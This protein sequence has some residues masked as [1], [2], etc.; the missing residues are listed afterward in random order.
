MKLSFKEPVR[1]TDILSS[2]NLHCIKRSSGA[3]KSAPVLIAIS[4]RNQPELLARALASAFSQTLVEKKIAQI[5]ILDDQSDC[6]WLEALENILA[7]PS[8]TILKA[9]CGSPAR[10]RNT[11]LDWAD[12]QKDI[13]WV[14]RLDADDE[15]FCSNSLEALYDS[16][17]SG[18]NIAAIGSNALRRNNNVIFDENIASSKILLDPDRLTSFI[19][20]FC[21]GDQKQELPS[22]NL[23]L[24]THTHLRYPGIRS[25]EDHWLLLRIL[26]LH[27]DQVSVVEAPI[28]SIY[29]LGGHSTVANRDKGSW[30]SSR[31]KLAWVADKVR[32]TQIRRYH[33]LGFGME[34]VVFRDAKN[35][36]KEFYPWAM[37]DKEVS[38]LRLILSSKELPIP[39]GQWKKSENEWSYISK[40]VYEQRPEQFI[41]KDK[42]VSFLKVLY[43]NRVV[44]LNIKRANLMYSQA[45]ELHYIDVGK[46]I[47]NLTTSYFLD[48]TAR[49]YAIGILG[50]SDEEMMRR[51]SIKKPDDALNEIP[52][53]SKF[54]HD[55]IKLL[56]PISS[57]ILDTPKTTNSKLDV[58]LLIK[59]CAQDAEGL[60]RQVEHI[61]TQ[62]SYPEKFKRI[63][64]LID[65]YPGPFLRQ[66]AEPNLDSLMNQANKLKRDKVID[67]ILI[68]PNTKVSIEAAYRRWFGSQEVLSSHTVSNAPLYPQIWAFTHIKTRYVLQCDCDVLVGR[69][70]LEHDF[71]A[72]MLSAI[73]P[74][75]VLSVG[76]NIPKSTS[77]FLE[78]HGAP[79]QF[80]PE[81]RFG[82]LD[83]VKIHK[84]LP[85]CNPIQEGRFKLTWHR[86]LQQHQRDS[87]T[88]TSL[89]GGDPAS[90]Y[91]HPCNADKASLR[92]GVIRDLISQGLYPYAQQEQFDLIPNADWHY[93]KRSESIIFLS[94]GRHTSPE[95]FKRCIES[96]RQQTNQEFGLIVIDDDSGFSNNWDYPKQLSFFEGRVTLIRND[97]HQGYIRNFFMAIEDVCCN[98]DSLITVLDQ[99]DFLM[100]K[101][102]VDQLRNAISKGYD[103]I[104]MPM[105]RP[106]KPINLYKPV[107]EGARQKGG[108]NTWAHLRAFTKQLFEKIP[109]NYLQRKDGIWFSSVTDYATMLPMSEL[110]E[111]PVFCDSGYAYWH[112]REDYSSETKKEQQSLLSEI[113]VKPSLQSEFG[114]NEVTAEPA[115]SGDEYLP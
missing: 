97:N 84:L 19:G 78:Y 35:T 22:C 94:K 29:S 36:I 104:Q 3:Y 89:R 112:E 100:Q 24:K 114:K 65:D 74:Q 64:L 33:L 68:A 63:S 66:Y 14:A 47:Q 7:H 46:D 28:Y 9:N 27:S 4:H 76:F 60:Y 91:V 38:R 37:N 16:A 2:R 20:A 50:Y 40:D 99:D 82:L 85:I 87:H 44:T 61:V 42:I 92:S 59:A 105:F 17:I 111:K 30:K 106:N 1:Y 75:T 49:L 6:P 11:I 102:I 31:K 25:A 39:S 72:D 70:D 21:N 32:Q 57:E 90:F 95:K 43:Q 62:L 55:L 107:Y 73:N 71:L 56:H 18:Q 45:G 54:Y 5:V 86:A 48:M 88:Y 93:P 52:G 26:L 69:K 110:A 41:D 34:G 12:T 23:L 77:K 98:P 113:M 10:S 81:V 13:T 8:I 115:P 108:G 53:F 101:D 103:L 80:A 96:L 67:E 15:F 51:K 58:T 83:L 109:K 79:G